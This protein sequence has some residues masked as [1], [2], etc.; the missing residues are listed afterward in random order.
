MATSK[1]DLTDREKVDAELISK[2]SAF[3]KTL[4]L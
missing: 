2:P 3:N 4:V 1:R